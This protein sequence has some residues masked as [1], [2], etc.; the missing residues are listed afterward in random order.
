VLKLIASEIT[1]VSLDFVYDT[2][3][4]VLSDTTLAEPPRWY[5]ILRNG[6]SQIALIHAEDTSVTQQRLISFRKTCASLGISVPDYYVKPAS[7]HDPKLSG[8]ATRELLT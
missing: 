2:R 1:T 4:S 3:T 8:L 7:Y 5:T 6:S